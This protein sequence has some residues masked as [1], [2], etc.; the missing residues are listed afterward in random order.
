MVLG[1]RVMVKGLIIHL[2]A[3]TLIEQYFSVPCH[4][5]PATYHLP[6]NTLDFCDD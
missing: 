4:L 2:I 3:K 1:F 6:P 5:P